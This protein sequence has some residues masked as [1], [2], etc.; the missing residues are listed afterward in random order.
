M[1]SNSSWPRVRNEASCSYHATSAR[2]FSWSWQ[3]TLRTQ[4]QRFS[5]I[6]VG[7]MESQ[8]ASRLHGMGDTRYRA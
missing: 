8:A 2:T 3:L 5:T 7:Q 1:S 4:N 6:S